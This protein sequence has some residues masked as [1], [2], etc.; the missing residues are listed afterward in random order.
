MIDNLPTGESL[1]NVALRIYFS[2][3]NDVVEIQTSFALRF[4]RYA[5]HM[6]K[7]IEEW[8]KEW[9]EYVEA[10][11]ADLQSACSLLQQSMELALKARICE[12]SPYLLLMNSGMRFSTAAKTV[13]FTELKTLDAVE[14][15]GAVN[16]LTDRPVSDEFVT[17][18][19]DLRSLRNKIMHLGE[20]KATLKPEDVIRLALKLYSSMWSERAWLAD[21]LEFAGQTRTAWLHDGKYTSTHMEVL[22]EWPFDLNLMTK[23][24]FKALFGR[25]KSK[26]RYLCHPCIDAGS[27]RYAAE[28]KHNWGTAHLD[29]GGT[30][31]TCLMCR[32]TFAIERKPC[33]HCEADVIAANGDEYDGHCH[34]CGEP[35]DEPSPEVVAD[36]KVDL[37]LLTGDVIPSA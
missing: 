21:R 15:P 4:D 20:A 22:E 34:S 36:P 33:L 1:N 18:Y 26:R 5:E 29:D 37:D 24:E 9:V 19:K 32:G 28:S 10:S 8:P 30:S 35:F 6:E 14:L 13:D 25:K 23:G 11:Q 3:W 16:T 17:T 27:T 7:A 12:V 31:V 2:A